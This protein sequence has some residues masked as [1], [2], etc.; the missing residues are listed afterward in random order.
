M[1]NIPNIPKTTALTAGSQSRLYIKRAA[2]VSLWTED[3]AVPLSRELGFTPS[4]SITTVPLFGEDFDRAVKTG[5]GG[6]LSIGTVAPESHPVVDALLDAGDAVGPGAQVRFLVI[7]PDGRSY[8]GYTVVENGTGQYDARNVFG[9]NFATTLDGK[10]IPFKA[11]P[12]DVGPAVLPTSVT[13][14]PDPVNVAVGATVQASALV[15]PVGARQ[16]VIWSTANTGIATISDIGLITGIAAG[17][18]IITA[19]AAYDQT[20]IGTVNVTV[21]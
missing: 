1:S 21:S 17:A 6:T 2:D 10:Y 11:N 20:V 13:I 3:D 12:N 7:N 4:G 19:K 15:A 5:K 9:Y 8:V 14:S 16:N 18:V